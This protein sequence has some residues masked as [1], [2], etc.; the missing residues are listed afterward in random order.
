[1]RQK[2]VSSFPLSTPIWHCAPYDSVKNASKTLSG[3]ERSLCTSCL[4]AC[5]YN[6]TVLA[7]RICPYYEY[8][9]LQGS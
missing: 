1:M 4:D 7:L 8:T 6:S 9:I 5:R 3:E 2:R